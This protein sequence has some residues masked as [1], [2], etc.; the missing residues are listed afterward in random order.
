MKLQ[1]DLNR[2]EIFEK[3][4]NDDLSKTERTQVIEAINK[5]ER[6]KKEFAISK[7]IH[8][9]YK[10]ERQAQL[11]QSLVD[12]EKKTSEKNTPRKKGRLIQL[13]RIAV[14]A[15]CLCGVIFLG[16]LTITTTP[17]HQELYANHFEVYPNVYNPIVRSNQSNTLSIDSQIM[18]FY[19]QREYHKSI[20]LYN[21]HYSFTEE[22]N[23]INFYMAISYMK[24]ENLE[25]AKSIFLTIPEDSKFYE[26][27]KWYLALCYLNENNL[28]EFTRIA[29]TLVYKKD[30]ADE[31]LN[32]LK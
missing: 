1:F 21:T 27:S 2:D 14:I 5:D 15:A 26:K 3:L 24:I 31:I 23:E 9:Y 17:N 32:T 13:Q 30:V 12:L 6:L 19:E 20:N 29:N 10:N 22:K 7:E 16:K 8:T 18:S 28:A 25:K 4:L 11:K